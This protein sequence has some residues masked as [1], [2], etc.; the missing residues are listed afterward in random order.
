MAKA[1][2]IKLGLRENAKQFWL[3]VLVNGFVGAMVGLER[4]VIPEFA[5]TVFGIN[6]HTALLSF[7]VAF[8]LAKSGANLAMGQLAAKY[9]R[10]QLLLTGWLFALP[11]PWLLLY[12]DAWWWVISANLLLGINQGLAWSATVVMKIDLVGEKN[13]GL[14]MGINEFAGYL[15][16]GLVA[17]LAGYIAF[18]SGDVTYAFVPGIG[19]SIIGLLLTIFLVRDTHSHVQTE[20]KQTN[21]PLLH[22]VWKDTTWRHGNLGSVT[23]NG[24]VNNLNDGILWGLL[25][26]LLS[27]KGY[28]LAETGLLA[29]IYPVV[30][31]LGQLVTGKLGDVL[32]KKQLLSIGMLLQGVAIGL[33]IFTGSYPVLVGTLVML[34]AGTALVYPNFLSVVAENTHPSQ[35]P[36]S[37]G[38]FRFW[39]DFGYVAGAV[40]AGVFGDLFGLKAVILGTAILTVG[41]GLLSECRM[42]C[43]QKLLWQS[44]ECR[45]SL[46]K[47]C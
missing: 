45:T 23:L 34:G 28:T 37:L 4:S 24:F 31:G 33:L 21:I 14:A 9:T 29:G 38:I 36:Q 46:V 19:F 43:T 42:C 30:W 27:S 10:R 20:V 40:A 12:A 3:L 18:T 17:F 1:S 2:D 39:R 15:A 25:P 8:G 7:I 11:V 6:G 5:E 47:P 44:K 41:A 26:V 32:C 13:R 22:N 35:R 16:V